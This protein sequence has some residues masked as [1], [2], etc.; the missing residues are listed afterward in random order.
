M[1][2]GLLILMVAVVVLTLAVPLIRPRAG[3]EARGT[4]LAVLRTQLAELDAGDPEADGLRQELK[5][6]ILAEGREATT[7]SRPLSPRTA[8]RLAIALAV[9]VALAGTGLYIRLGRPDLTAGVRVAM[10]SAQ[11]EAMVEAANGQVTPAARAVFE[12]VLKLDPTDARARFYLAL[13]KDQAGDTA[14][15]MDAWVALIN[16]APPGAAW[17]P[18]VRAIV[19]RRAAQEGIDLSQRLKP[20]PQAAM[21]AAMVDRLDAKLKAD[22]NDL[23][24]WIQLMRSRVV[25]GEPDKASAA[26]AKAR[27]TF[28]KDEKSLTVLDSAAKELGVE[29]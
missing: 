17:V 18:E 23:E 28:A 8:K 2:W 6:R 22:P 1:F 26:Y 20:D 7:P 24:G 3:R 10:T 4:T 12:D 9:I 27:E 19:E 25:L 11:G 21:I 29:P 15:A 5:R 16:D 13:A 14:A